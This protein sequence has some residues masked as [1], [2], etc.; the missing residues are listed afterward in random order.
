M[1]DL[2]YP[3]MVESGIA[4][5]LETPVWMDQNGNIVGEKDALGK[6]VDYSL[7][8][9][10]CL[11][12]VDEVGNNMNVKD[13][14]RV[15]GEKKIGA[16]G[17]RAQQTVASNDAHFTVLGFTVSLQCVLQYSRHQK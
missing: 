11:V 1:H 12:F 7:K 10:E 3:Q 2:I 13:D 6:M 17:E 4:K 9:P 16:K 14:G 15:G 5:R 8:H